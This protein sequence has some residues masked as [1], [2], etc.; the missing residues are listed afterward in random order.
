MVDFWT[1]SKSKLIDNDDNYTRTF[2]K[3]LCEECICL[4]AGK[5]FSLYGIISEFKDNEGWCKMD[6]STGIEI[7]YFVSPEFDDQDSYTINIE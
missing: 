3:M 5:N 4:G 6:G 1:G 7:T 2:L